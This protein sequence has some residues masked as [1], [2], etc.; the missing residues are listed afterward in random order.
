MN[1]H[2]EGL[3]WLK[4]RLLELHEYLMGAISEY[5][6]IPTHAAGFS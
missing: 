4:Q 1:I 6:R 5:I 3:T 2:P